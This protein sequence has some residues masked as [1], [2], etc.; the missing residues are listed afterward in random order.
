MADAAEVLPA[1]P[2]REERS[3]SPRHRLTAK[4]RARWRS[5]V[6]RL[7]KQLLLALVAETRAREEKLRDWVASQDESLVEQEAQLEAVVD[8]VLCLRASLLH[9]LVQRYW[10]LL[11]RD[12]ARNRDIHC[13]AQLFNEE[14]MLALSQDQ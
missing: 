9:D 13:A 8:W 1:P 10:K 11:E 5:I 3:R 7:D 12:S 2:P 4:Q 14:F 6:N